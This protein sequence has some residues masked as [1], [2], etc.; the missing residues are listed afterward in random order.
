MDGPSPTQIHW[1][2]IVEAA[3]VGLAQQICRMPSMSP[4][5]VRLLTEAARELYWLNQNA[6]LF[7]KRIELELSRTMPED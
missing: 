1:L 3:R 4:L 6:A 2:E 7:D 5:D